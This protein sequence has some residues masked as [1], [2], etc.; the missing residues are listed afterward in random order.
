[1]SHADI[2]LVKDMY[3]AF[4]RGDIATITAALS[5]D[6]VWEL[7]GRR[8]DHPI[9]GKRVGPAQAADFFRVLAETVDMKSFTPQ[10]FH[11][12][13]GKVFVLGENSYGN[14][15]SGRTV[16]SRWMHVFTIRDGKVAAFLDFIDTAL[17]VDV[18]R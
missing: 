1:M 13:D 4:G 8:E 9:L 11:A 2:A 3:A 14:R 16:A 7:N 15:R 12:A 17:L 18:S 5:A 10:A 6:V